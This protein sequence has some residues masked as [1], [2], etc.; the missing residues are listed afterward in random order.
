MELEGHHSDQQSRYGVFG[1]YLCKLELSEINW[2]LPNQKNAVYFMT[3][4]A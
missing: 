2:E 1:T 3:Y 4:A